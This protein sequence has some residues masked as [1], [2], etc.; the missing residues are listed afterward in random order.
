MLQSVIDKIPTKKEQAEI[1]LI[2]EDLVFI[3]DNMYGI[4]PYTS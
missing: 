1:D 4:T 3:I 2:Q